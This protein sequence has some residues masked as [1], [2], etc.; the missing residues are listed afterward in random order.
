MKRH[1]IANATILRIIYGYSLRSSRILAGLYAFCA[2]FL[3]SPLTAQDAKILEMENI[4][5]FASK[6]T[7]AWNAAAKDQ[8]LRVGDRIRTRQR[9]RAT[10]ALTGLFTV[11][12][13]HFTTIEITPGLVDANK[14]KLD[15]S[16]GAAFIFSR[17]KANEMDITMPGANAALRG[18]QLFVSVDANGKSQIQVLEGQ[19]ELNNPHGKLLLN[20]GEAGEAV[21]G[22]APRRTAVI[23]AKNLLQWALYYPAIVDLADVGLTNTEKALYAGSIASYTKGDLLRAV[24]KLPAGLPTGVS[25]RLYQSAVLLSVGRVDESEKLLF[26]VPKNHPA[27]KAI[28]RMMISVK[29][30]QGTNWDVASLQTISEAMAES[31]FQQSKANLVAATAATRKA[32]DL[33]PQNGFAWTRLAELEFSAGRTREALA[34]VEKAAQFTPDNARLHALRGFIL[35]ADNQIEKGRAAF[36]KCVLLDGSFGNGWLGLGL[37]KIKRGDLEGGR[38]DLQTAATVEPTSSLFHSYL[39]K[40]MSQNGRDA[41]AMKDLMLARQLDPND[42]TPWLYLAIEN[43]RKNRTNEAIGD[44]QESIRLNDNRRI[45]RSEFL[46]DQDR[47]VRSS[48][49]AK[50]YQNAG[51]KDVAFREATRAVESDYTNGSAH[52]FLANSFDALRDP[53]R[54]LLRYETGWFNELLLSNLL[55]PV[56]GGPLSQFVSQQEYSKLLEADGLG[57]SLVTNWRST[58]EQR[59]SASVFGTHGNVSYGLDAYYR[60]DEGARKNSDIELKELYGQLKWQATPD[61]IVY[62]LGKWSDQKQGDLFETFNDLPLTEDFRFE[63]NQEPGLLLGGWNHRWRP[64]SNTLLLVGRL[65]A[66]QFLSDRNAPQLLVQRDNSALI[67]G[68]MQLNNIGRMSFT[69]PSLAGGIARVANDHYTYTPA[70]ISAIQPYLGSGD[71][72]EEETEVFDFLTRRKFEI[73]TS[74]IQHIEQQDKHTMLLGGRFQHGTIESQSRMIFRGSYANATLPTPAVDQKIKSDFTRLGLYAYD[75]WQVLPSLTLVGGLAWDWIDHPENFRNP[76]LSEK[77]RT[78]EAFSG[79][80]GFTWAPSKWFTLRGAAAEGLGGLSYDESVRLEPSQ[81]SG[82]GQAYRT[83]ISESITGSVETPEYSIL[84][85]SVEG[86]LP[87]RTWWGASGGII[88]QDVRRS[89]GMFTGYDDLPSPSN[90][91][92]FADQTEEFLDYREFYF[93]VGINQLIGDQ[94]S[95]GASWNITRSE[96]DTSRPE[97]GPIFGELSDIATLSRISLFA[98]W[99]SPNGYFA[100]MEANSYSQKLNRDDTYLITNR[101]GDASNDLAPR[102]GD[103][104]VQ[105]NAWVGYRFNDNLCEF[106]VGVLNISDSDYSL[107]PLNPYSDIARERTYFASFRMSF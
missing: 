53:D 107:S 41:E 8:S 47:A 21:A 68:F 34:A 88:N 95:V 59:T 2:V 67:P 102:N 89:L 104:F 52:L 64:G 85:L 28:E 101:D 23:E 46:L 74:E 83:V 5:Q 24:E 7:S 16:A 100:H 103:D 10:V 86:W 29:G 106:A 39:G 12:L 90:P 40:A 20:S 99:N 35:C 57:A 91:V 105:F 93:N 37:T 25:G 87:T 76:P 31:Y 30:K 80:L 98:D 54:T 84:G 69:D 96:L 26:A 3:L 70:V 92:Y 81:I 62:F 61:D 42:P 15:F 38:R 44:L 14:P 94:L 79:K 97:L 48:N 55:S 50:I 82:F 78:D 71:I 58:D 75:Y 77:Q 63:E 65:A 32:T 72:L 6:G 56:G 17:E 60:N 18:T 73:F 43:Q 11:R 1:S 9:S 19:V 13:D 4:V 22:K 51:M 27:R 45:Y 33:A 36:E 49:L 66:S